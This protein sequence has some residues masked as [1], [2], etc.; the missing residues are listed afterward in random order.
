MLSGTETSHFVPGARGFVGFEV[1][2]PQ[3]ESELITSAPARVE[4]CW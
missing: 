2:G 1:N 3:Y 4:S